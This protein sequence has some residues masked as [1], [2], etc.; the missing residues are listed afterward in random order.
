MDVILENSNHSNDENDTNIINIKKSHRI[1]R[2]TDSDD[3]NEQ[4]EQSVFSKSLSDLNQEDADIKSKKLT[5]IHS[6]IL[7]S[8]KNNG[9]VSD[10]SDHINEEITVQNKSFL[11]EE[12]ASDTGNVNPEKENEH[13]GNGKAQVL[14]HFNF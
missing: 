6:T 10:S 3:E 12:S 7:N 2:I 13:F 4:T 9:D 11:D 14:S 5:N 1:N 8:S